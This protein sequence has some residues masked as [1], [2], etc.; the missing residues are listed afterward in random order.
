MAIRAQRLMLTVPLLASVL[1][2]SAFVLVSAVE[3]IGS[4]QGSALQGVYG[5]RDLRFLTATGNS[6]AVCDKMDFPVPQAMALAIVS[7]A[8][9]WSK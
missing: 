4:Q 3:S 8:T 1:A 6:T 7:R 5:H 9:L 2:A